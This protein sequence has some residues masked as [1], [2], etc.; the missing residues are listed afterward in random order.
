MKFTRV[1]ELARQFIFVNFSETQLIKEA[2]YDYTDL[3]CFC[4]SARM[5]GFASRLKF[6]GICLLSTIYV[7]LELE[8]CL[9]GNR[10]NVE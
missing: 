1:H 6:A 8:N 7:D 4:L 9:A 3:K 10:K 2:H 5:G